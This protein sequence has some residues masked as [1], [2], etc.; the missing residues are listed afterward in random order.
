MAKKK[1]SSLAQ[2]V[3]GAATVG[4]PPPARA[5]LTKPLVAGFL[6]L[7][8]PALWA[9]GIIQVQWQDGM[10]KLSIN[11]QRAEQV[12]EESVEEISEFHEG[13]GGGQ[14]GLL[15]N[16]PLVG[17]KSTA[18]SPFG[19]TKPLQ[20]LQAGIENGVEKFEQQVEQAPAAPFG[21]GE[22]T[23]QPAGESQSGFRPFARLREK[24]DS[25]QR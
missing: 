9:L 11:R 12:R 3:V 1:K 25:T 20:E 2:N 23:T 5:V 16:V 24:F 15:E 10:P 13:H 7:V 19:E 4:L 8:A 21:I 22:N 14:H 17:G 6:V 18:Q